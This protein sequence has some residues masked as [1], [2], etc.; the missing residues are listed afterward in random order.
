MSKD[1]TL[2]EWV[3]QYP[4]TESLI[5]EYDRLVG[6]CILCKCLFDPINE[7]ESA[8]KVNLNNLYNRLKAL[9]EK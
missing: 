1:R 7:I 4:E 9:T 3:E 2:L 5:R 6:C 8:Y